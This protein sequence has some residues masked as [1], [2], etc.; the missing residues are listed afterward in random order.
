VKTNSNNFIWSIVNLLR[1][2]EI[3]LPEDVKSALIRAENHR[4][5]PGCKIPA[6]SNPEKH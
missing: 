4:R 1:K 2:A 3:E 6:S 5:K